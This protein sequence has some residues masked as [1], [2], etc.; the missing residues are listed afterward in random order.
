MLHVRLAKRL[1][2]RHDLL[3]GNYHVQLLA[4]QTYARHHRPLHTTHHVSCHP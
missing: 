4:Q 3:G 2:A 1:V